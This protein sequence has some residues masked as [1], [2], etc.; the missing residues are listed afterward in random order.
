LKQLLTQ[1]TESKL[2]AIDWNKPF[3]I[4]T[5]ASEF[6]I[7]GCMSQTDDNVFEQPITFFS[8]KLDSTQ[9]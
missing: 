9:Q 1:A 2:H 6:Y 5:D 3:N 4:C 7:A 8:K